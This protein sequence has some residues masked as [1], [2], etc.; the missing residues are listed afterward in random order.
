MLIRSATID[1]APEIARIHVESWRVAYRGQIADVVLAAQNVEQ[2]AAFW[3]DRL[4][5]GGRSVFVAEQGSVIGFCDLIPS[6]DKDS[7]PKVAEIGGMYVHP[8]H[9][10]KGIGRALCRRALAEAERQGFKR[11]TLWALATNGPAQSFYE[12]MGFALDGAAKTELL[13]DGSELHEIR[14]RRQAG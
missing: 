13:A 8:S 7:G 5:P 3:R 10:R 9:W 2:R 4:P 14:F 1:D 12:A 6:R 11:V